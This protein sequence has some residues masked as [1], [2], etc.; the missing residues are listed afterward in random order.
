MPPT[1]QL[2]SDPLAT[3]NEWLDD[4]APGCE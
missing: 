1:G 2:D 4:G 3:L